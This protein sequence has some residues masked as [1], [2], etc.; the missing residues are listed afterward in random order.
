MR[1]LGYDSV[2]EH[3]RQA[4]RELVGGKYVFVCLPMGHGKT[5]CYA[6]FTIAV[7]V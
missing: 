6:V 1:A 3:Q 7:A 5:L 4:I 2:R